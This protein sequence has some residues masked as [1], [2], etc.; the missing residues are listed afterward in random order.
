MGVDVL[1][2]EQAGNRRWS[3]QAQLDFAAANARTLFTRNVRDY[4]VLH[5]EYRSSGR[6]HAGIIL[7]TDIHAPIGRQ[8]QC[9]GAI[10]RAFP[11]GDLANRALFLLNFA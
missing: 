6:N 5:R 2:A 9:F 8:L 7:L 1:T 3:D 4:R 10:D 11:T